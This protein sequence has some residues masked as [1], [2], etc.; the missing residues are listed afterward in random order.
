MFLRLRYV[1]S[2][3]V[4]YEVCNPRKRKPMRDNGNLKLKEIYIEKEDVYTT[5]V[6]TSIYLYK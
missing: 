1:E 4:N 2:G 6:V 3:R 5:A